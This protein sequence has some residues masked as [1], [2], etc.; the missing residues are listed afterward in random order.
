[1][2]ALLYIY[3]KNIISVAV[4]I[5][6]CIIRT[7]MNISTINQTAITPPWKPPE[8]MVAV[9]AYAANLLFGLPINVYVTW[10]IVSGRQEKIA[11]DFIPLNQIVIESLFGLSGILYFLQGLLSPFLENILHFLNIMFMLMRPL[12]QSYLCLEHYFATVHP[13]IFLWCKPLRYKVAVCCVSWLT[14]IALSIVVTALDASRKFFFFLAV[15]DMFFLMLMT[16]CGV[17]VLRALKRPAPGEGQRDRGDN[18]KKKAFMIILIY[19]VTTTFSQLPAPV[20]LVCVSI[21]PVY[22][23]PTL[24][25][26]AVF[27]YVTISFVPSMM[28]LYR[29]GKLFSKCNCL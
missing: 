11:L 10:L 24:L 5:S 8:E 25:S 6:V 15:L 16:F 23:F 26:M 18:M 29:V 17:S 19:L 22:M 13:V 9:V 2:Y 1:M 20:I 28:Y 12:M 4:F 27:I 21:T 7:K 14:A 3:N